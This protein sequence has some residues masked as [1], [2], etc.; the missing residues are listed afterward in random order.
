MPIDGVKEIFAQLTPQELQAV[1]IALQ[2][3]LESFQMMKLA[4]S[5]FVDWNTEEDLYSNG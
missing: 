5:A 3:R 2:D 1:F 4:E